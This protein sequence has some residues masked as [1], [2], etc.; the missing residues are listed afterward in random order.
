[1]IAGG[2]AWPGLA[3]PDLACE[4]WYDTFFYDLDDEDDGIADEA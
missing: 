1:M 2:L 4:T 3:W